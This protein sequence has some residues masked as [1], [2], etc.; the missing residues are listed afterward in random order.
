MH[1]SVFSRLCQFLIAQVLDKYDDFWIV[2]EDFDA[3]TWVIE[4][5]KPTKADRMRRIAIGIQ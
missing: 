2:L 1:C 4:P 3:H 5:E